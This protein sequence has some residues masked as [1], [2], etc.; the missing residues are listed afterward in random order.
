MML[1]GINL[2]T[3][4]EGI[5][6]RKIVFGFLVGVLLVNMV[7]CRDALAG[8]RIYD[9]G[10]KSA[11]YYGDPVWMRR[12]QLIAENITYGLW[13]CV[14]QE[15]SP[16]GY[17]VPCRG[18]RR[19]FPL[20]LEKPSSA[21]W[22][23]LGFGFIVVNGRDIPAFSKAE[24]KVVKD[25]PDIG[26]MEIIW[27][28]D[29]CDVKMR[30]IVIS[31]SDSL[32]VEFKIIPTAESL[33]S[34]RVVLK[35]FPSSY[36]KPRER[37]IVTSKRA[38]KPNATNGGGGELDLTKEK[39]IFY[40]DEIHDPAIDESRDTEGP[41]GLL[42]LPFEVEKVRVG[43]SGPKDNRD[44]CVDTHFFLNPENPVIHLA[45]WDFHKWENDKALSKPAGDIRSERGLHRKN[46]T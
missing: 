23:R 33:K 20:G 8:G 28:A 6:G 24:F 42:Y 41:S 17:L 1:G 18:F 12:I 31:G 10:Q 29:T 44:Y 46:S 3:K 45:L 14:L 32:F 36:K 22:S 5:M 40:G 34:A 13:Y 25:T 27:K 43:T 19:N 38:F 37:I 15:P 2:F 35:N 7:F 26:E 16:H 39:W 21:N 9:S 11:T 4:K 30:F